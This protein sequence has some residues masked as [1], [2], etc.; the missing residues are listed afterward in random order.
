MAILLDHVIV[1]SH[2]R[3]EAAKFLAGLLGVS[4]EASRGDFTPVYVNE[5]LTFDF[6]DREQFESHHYCGKTRTVTSG[7]SSRS[8]T[9]GRIRPL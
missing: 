1:P 3:L 6:A 5:T 4:W 8:A 7:K 2:N 9:P